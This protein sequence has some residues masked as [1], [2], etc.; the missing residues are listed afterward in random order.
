MNKTLL[1]AFFFF[2]ALNAFGDFPES[3]VHTHYP[4]RG[5][6]LSDTLFINSAPPE[7][8]LFIGK[9]TWDTGKE[10][11]K[12]FLK[13][14]DHS[15]RSFTAQQILD[16]ELT[17][18]SVRLLIMPGGE[19]WEYSKELGEQGASTILEFVK[20]G[21]GYMGICAGAF[22]ATSHRAGGYST[23]PYGIGLLRG[24]AYD[25]TALKKEPFIEGMMDL[26][27]VSHLLT[28]GFPATFRIVMFGGPSF[29]YDK[30]E[31]EHKRIRVM[32]QFQKIHEPA[33]ITFHY[34]RGRVFLSGPHLEIEEDRTDWGKEFEDP[35]SEWL[36]LE[37]VTSFLL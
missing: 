8:G 25:G 18:D 2:F 20:A 31:E 16:G 22:Y 23:G 36:M 5:Q 34:G 35:D 6:R 26:D 28:L 9:G 21:N 37:R 17:K 7:I 3:R 30:Q 27:I 11:L 4:F 33:M 19:S 13:E 10:H 1:S 12:M 14:H 24:T 15:Y 32:A 29:L